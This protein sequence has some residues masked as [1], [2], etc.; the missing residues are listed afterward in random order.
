M[1]VFPP[2]DTLSLGVYAALAGVI[3]LATRLR[4]SNAFVALIATAPFDFSHAVGATT[5]TFDKVALLAAIIGLGL[6][7]P[8]VAIPR[9]IALAILAVVVTTF[10]T[11]IV[12]EYRGPVIRETFK[13]IEYLLIFALAA[14]AWRLDP[15]EDR[16]RLATILTVVVVAVLALAQLRIGSPSVIAIAGSV[17]PR[18]TG[19]I[20]GPNQLAAYLGLALPFFTIWAF[21]RVTRMTLL[22]IALTTATLVLTLSRAGVLCAAVE[23]A[24]VFALSTRG[25]RATTAIAYASGIAGAAGLLVSWNPEILARFLWFGETA[26]AGGVGKRSILWRAAYRLWE[27]RPILGVGAGNFE[28]MLP[29]IGDIG[30]R[31]HA[32]S[33]YLQSLAEGGLPLLLATCGLVWTSIGTFIRT[34]RKPLC[35]AAFAASIAFAL[36]GFVD[37]LVFYP[38]V[39]IMWFALLGIA[40]EE[41]VRSSG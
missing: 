29:R 28:L 7:R 32:N 4:P 38:K 34:L 26:D 35:L 19:P 36:H 9:G 27:Q 41:A 11:I 31:T 23:I 30:I 25:A 20:E 1:P 14:T 5:I 24:V 21:E 10:V 33:W 40:A 12:A 2:I 37:Y 22:A 16:L 6:R 13:W 17:F 15:D 3:V 8:R 39:A 18:I